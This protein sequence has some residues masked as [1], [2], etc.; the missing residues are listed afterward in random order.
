MVFLLYFFPLFPFLHSWVVIAVFS[1]TGK[2]IQITAV[3]DEKWPLYKMLSRP[4]H[5]APSKHRHSV[6]IL[7]SS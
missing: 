6:V 7:Y 1:L 2:F 4:Y 5:M 3:S